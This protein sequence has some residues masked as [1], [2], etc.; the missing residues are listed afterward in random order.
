MY[1]SQTQETKFGYLA[2]R[3]GGAG[4]KG[5]PPC[6]NV[7]GKQTLNL[8]LRKNFKKCIGSGMMLALNARLNMDKI[9]EGILESVF[10]RKKEDRPKGGRLR[11]CLHTSG[12]FSSGGASHSQVLEWRGRHLKSSATSVI[13]ICTRCVIR[14]I[15]III[16][17]H[18]GVRTA[19]A[20]RGA[21][22][23]GPYPK[24]T[25]RGTGWGRKSP[26]GSWGLWAIE[27]REIF[28]PMLIEIYHPYRD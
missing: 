3:T 18:C 8:P 2:T 5:K 12:L 24:P 11:A 13:V 23:E 15:V 20:S 25:L 26:P 6:M 7:L 10:F 22:V 9:E 19:P 28:G 16:D 1:K 21:P 17:T 14:R 4:T 27:A